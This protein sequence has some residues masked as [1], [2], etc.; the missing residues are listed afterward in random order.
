MPTTRLV[1][2]SDLVAT[3]PIALSIDV[4]FQ[5]LRKIFHAAAAQRGAWQNLRQGVQEALGGPSI[6]CASVRTLERLSSSSTTAPSV[7][8]LQALRRALA[9]RR[10]RQAALKHPRSE[11]DGRF[12]GLRK[13]LEMRMV[14]LERELGAG[15]TAMRRLLARETETFALQARERSCAEV[16]GTCPF[17]LPARDLAIGLLVGTSQMPESLPELLRALEHP[18]PPPQEVQRWTAQAL[19]ALSEIDQ[20][21]RWCVGD[22]LAR[23]LVFPLWTPEVR[24][25]RHVRQLELL[26]W[27]RM[28]TGTPRERAVA[29]TG[30][31]ALELLQAADCMTKA[32]GPAETPDVIAQ[33]RG[34]SVRPGVGALV[35]RTLHEAGSPAR[36]IS[37][38]RH[39][40]DVA[41][42]EPRRSGRDRRQRVDDPPQAQ[43]PDEPR[44]ATG[45]YLAA[46]GRDIEIGTRS[47]RFTL[48]RGGP[49]RKVT[50]NNAPGRLLLWLALGNR[51]ALADS[52][53]WTRTVLMRALDAAGGVLTLV[54]RGPGLHLEPLPAVIDAALR[55]RMP[56]QPLLSESRERDR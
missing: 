8:A 33:L 4:K 56:R 2:G 27:A 29:V 14:E 23:D 22:T 19:A 49:E 24:G 44:L 16:D 38:L 12:E 54:G 1:L 40:L 50:A 21:A 55:R 41:T 52:P 25:A 11:A 43:T 39:L 28:L 34:V 48:R 51:G 6:E 53:R 37:Q 31:V 3:L 30:A 36:A 15:E 42:R 20:I 17:D 32:L 18:A 13:R 26:E 47:L 35:R 7:A 10:E 9:R 45:L 46:N 5:A